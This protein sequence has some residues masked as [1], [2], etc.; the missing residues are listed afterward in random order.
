MVRAAISSPSPV[1]ET[2]RYRGFRWYG[3]VYGWGMGVQ[4][5]SGAPISPG[6]PTRGFSM[7]DLRSGETRLTL[8]TLGSEGEPRG[9][10]LEAVRVAAEGQFEILGELG[11]GSEGTIAYLARDLSQG[12]LVALR[13][14]PESGNNYHYLLTVAQ[15]LDGTVP[16]SGAGCLRCAEPLRGWGRFCPK[17]GY[18]LSGVDPM[19]LI[20]AG[21][22]VSDLVGELKGDECEVLGEMERAEGGGSVVFAK[23]P[24]EGTI[25]GLRVRKGKGDGFAVDET[26]EITYLPSTVQPGRVA[27]PMGV[28]RPEGVVEPVPETRPDPEDW[29]ES[30]RTP[31]DKRL[32]D[33]A[34]AGASGVTPM[35]RSTV[36]LIVLAALVVGVLAGMFLR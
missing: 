4:E 18:D 11:R 10:F 5:I 8:P 35:S 33:R 7:Q 29:A 24:K 13:L 3:I 25:V 23:Q 20:P 6:I 15:E 2:K 14:E 1:K 17:C 19:D 30:R 27:E 28:G 32:V 12:R 34:A 9:R 31:Q 21:F 36:V 16:S 22:D 26:V